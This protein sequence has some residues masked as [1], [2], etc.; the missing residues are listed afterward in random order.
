MQG[1]AA[2]RTLLLAIF[3]LMAGSGFLATLVS[4]RLEARGV[5]PLMIGLIATS[6]FAGLT[7]GSLGVSRLIG[8]VGHIRAFAAFV[9]LFS[10]STLTYAVLDSVAIWGG[11]RFVDGLCM[12]GV[13]V[14]L[15]SWLNERA[16]ARTRGSILAF[17]MIALY[18][19]QAIGQ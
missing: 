14:C 13:F 1:I 6:Y 16:E 2:V 12:A 8:R 3:I 10:A 19:G 11:L 5:S 9:S 15:E 7:L 17:Y 4:L 18:A